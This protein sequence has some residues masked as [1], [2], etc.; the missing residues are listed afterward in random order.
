MSLPKS[1][2]KKNSRNLFLSRPSRNFWRTSWIFSG[3]GCK[4]IAV[5]NVA[6]CML[7]S[8]MYLLYN[9][10]NPPFFSMGNREACAV[11]PLPDQMGFSSLFVFFSS[12]SFFFVIFLIFF[13]LVCFLSSFILVFLTLLFS[14][15][16]YI[17]VISFSLHLSSFPSYLPSF[18]S[19][20]L[21]SFLSFFLSVF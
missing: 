17:L 19:F 12:H 1:G 6:V 14:F 20:F 10:V 8:I 18:L 21:P 4:E 3:V 15:F 16:S 2:L 7:Y 5:P 11:I 13:L 9:A